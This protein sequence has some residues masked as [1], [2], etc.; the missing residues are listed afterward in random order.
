M[1]KMGEHYWFVDWRYF[2]RLLESGWTPELWF[3]RYSVGF[4]DWRYLCLPIEVDPL[5][6]VC[7]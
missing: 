6:W 1:S 3:E 4:T 7:E 5:D 2:A